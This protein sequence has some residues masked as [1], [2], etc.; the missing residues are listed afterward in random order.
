MPKARPKA[1]QDS[2]LADF[3]TLAASASSALPALSPRDVAEESLHIG[4]VL[5]SE[6]GS[7][8][9]E[10]EASTYALFP[11]CGSCASS[12]S[13]G[14][15]LCLPTAPGAPLPSWPVE[16]DGAIVQHESQRN[17]LDEEDH[18]EAFMPPVLV[19]DTL[20]ASGGGTA[21]EQPVRLRTYDLFRLGRLLDAPLFHVGV[22]VAGLEYSYGEFGVTA[23]FVTASERERRRCVGNHIFRESLEIGRTM[24]SEGRVE[25][26][27]KELKV[28][29][30]PGK[31][32][33]LGANCQAFALDF[34]R[35]LGLPA[36]CIPERYRLLADTKWPVT[37]AAV[38]G[39]L[40]G[41]R[42]V[43]PLCSGAAPLCSA[44]Q[45]KSSRRK[46]RHSSGKKHVDPN[47]VVV[48]PTAFPSP[49][50]PAAWL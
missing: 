48:E 28:A 31:Y 44:G 19:C 42:G 7:H 38:N 30:P 26:V 15:G 50:M 6:S 21:A 9:Q 37:A 24:L 41:C 5:G 35:A 12:A 43:Q 2:A 45:R 47:E 11:G 1:A 34:C 10:R 4:E 18:P 36:G 17:L 14:R 16:L 3:L 39:A 29:W 46:R 40:L 23:C 25:D 27:I 49:A 22:E 33:P 8:L 13:A 32:S 20:R